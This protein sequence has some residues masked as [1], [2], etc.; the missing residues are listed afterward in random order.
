M[1]PERVEERVNS[2]VT[3]TVM[4]ALEEE[5]RRIVIRESGKWVLVGVR[6]L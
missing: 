6:K 2:L 3:V 5:K 1:P 4:L